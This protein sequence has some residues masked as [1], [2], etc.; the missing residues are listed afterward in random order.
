MNKWK[1]VLQALLTRIRLTM[2]CVICGLMTIMSVL[3]SAINNSINR[4][5]K[6]LAWYS[7]T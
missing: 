4:V 1:F 6:S 5:I 3:L 2:R 7:H